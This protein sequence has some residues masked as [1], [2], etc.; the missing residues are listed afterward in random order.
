MKSDNLIEYLRNFDK[1]I[2]NVCGSPK[3][4][5]GIDDKCICYKC[6]GYDLLNREEVKHLIK[7][8]KRRLREEFKKLAIKSD[9][10]YCLKVFLSLGEYYFINEID[11]ISIKPDNSNRESILKIDLR[12]IAIAI[13]ELNGC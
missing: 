1:G 3:G 6:H 9:I 13:W 12:S 10:F 11:K 7:R 4:H 2:C 8:R 5:F